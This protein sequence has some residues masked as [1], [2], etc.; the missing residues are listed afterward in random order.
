MKKVFIGII[1]VTITMTMLASCYHLNDQSNIS[2]TGQTNDSTD[3]L[4]PYL[5]DSISETHDTTV[6]VEPSVDK[7]ENKMDLNSYMTYF[8]NYFHDEYSSKITI[9]DEDI[10]SLIFH[11][12]YSHNSYLDFVE[13]NE[14]TQTMYIEGNEFREISKILLG[15]SFEAT[16]YHSF[17]NSGETADKYLK[18]EDVYLVPTAKGYWGGDL[19]Y[20][21][22][23]AE[24]EI[25]ETDE[26]AIVIA[27]VYTDNNPA[28]KMQYEFKKIV[29]DGFLY[30]QINAVNL[31]E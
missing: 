27:S 21:E 29:Y 2:I 6:N 16:E 10:L 30:Y 24:L 9:K 25:S 26:E 23:G 15:D 20:L 12:C 31:V 1:V 3:N 19:Y 17:F 8:V 5:S 14:E 13:I 28:A 7:Y 11:F 22:F 4:E 18:G